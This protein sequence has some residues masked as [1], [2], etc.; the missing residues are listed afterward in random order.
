MPVGD[1]TSSEG[2]VTEG[3]APDCPKDRK[4]KIEP[5]LQPM[6]TPS[7]GIESGLLPEDATGLWESQYVMHDGEADVKLSST[8]STSDF[9]VFWLGGVEMLEK[10]IG[11]VREG[12]GFEG[13]GQDTARNNDTRI[14]ETDIGRREHRGEESKRD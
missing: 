8:K 10:V 6:A 2:M 5:S 3:T 7:A 11:T 14:R 9:R 12:S 4:T 1:D 13:I